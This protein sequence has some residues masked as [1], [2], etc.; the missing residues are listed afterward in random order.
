MELDRAE[1]IC[2]GCAGM[3]GLEEAITS[4]LGVPVIDGVAAAVRLAE[5]VVGLGLKTSKVST[6]AASGGQAHYRLAALRGPR[7]EAAPGSRPPCPQRWRPAMNQL[8]TVEAPVS[9]YEMPERQ[10]S[11]GTEVDLA[12]RWL[13]GS[14]LAASDESFGEKE[15]LLTPTPS[16]FVPATTA[17]AARSLTAGKPGAGA[18]PATTG[19]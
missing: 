11:F 2:L 15:A 7:L 4:E 1:V 9:G 13:G 19:R 14:V 18:S 10:E 5:A 8:L 6:Y 3:A 12:S 16:A 17:R